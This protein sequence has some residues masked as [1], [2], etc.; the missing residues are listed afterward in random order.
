MRASP[1]KIFCK[2]FYIL[3]FCGKYTDF[4]EIL[5]KIK[6]EELESIEA[7]VAAGL[8]ECRHLASFVSKGTNS[9]THTHTHTHTHTQ[10]AHT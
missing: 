4:S 6:T 3:T 10:H 7:A 9:Q 8:A 2:A 5:V 1:G